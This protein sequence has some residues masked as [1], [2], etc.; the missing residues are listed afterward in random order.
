MIVDKAR[1]NAIFK[2]LV[3]AGRDPRDFNLV[4]EMII[5][6]A[7]GSAFIVARG[8]NRGFVASYTVGDRD[9]EER[10]LLTWDQ[11]LEMI[12]RWVDE[13]EQD[14]S[15]PD[16]WEE[17]RNDSDV[18]ALV[19]A[20]D[21]DNAPFTDAERAEVLR[22]LQEVRQ[23]A[24]TALGLSQQQIDALEGRLGYLEEAAERL[25]RKDW[26]TIALGTLVGLVTQAIISPDEVRN[27]ITMLLQ[28]LGHLFGHPLPPLPPG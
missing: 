8:P 21:V 28:P 13:V 3:S 22:Q 14:A 24:E 5:H 18:V 23:Y 9:D 4:G 1:R 25:G 17:L 26:A 12:P 19:S 20:P 11:V 27:I 2:A 16:L 10:L 15:A 6:R 7:T